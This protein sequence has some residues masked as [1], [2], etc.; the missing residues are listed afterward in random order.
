[1]AL[2][3][4]AVTGAAA[5]SLLKDAIG[6]FA[7]HEAKLHGIE[8]SQQG[9][10]AIQAS[11]L[12]FSRNLTS[13]MEMFA[14]H[15]GARTISTADLKM[16]LRKSEALAS[17]VRVAEAAYAESMLHPQ[18]QRPAAAD[19]TKKRGRPPKNVASNAADGVVRSQSA[20]EFIGNSPSA[21]ADAI[22]QSSQNVSQSQQVE[23]DMLPRDAGAAP[24]MF[25]PP[26]SRIV[27]FFPFAIL[28]RS[29]LPFGFQIYFLLT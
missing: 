19:G 9:V 3:E 13:D 15:R 11:A 12:N 16:A 5:R 2:S 17:S 28:K 7:V 10:A 21:V 6:A 1:M 23:L 29:A 25:K 22:F 27:R 20:V 18:A 4:S 14:L 8:L 24:P 26:R